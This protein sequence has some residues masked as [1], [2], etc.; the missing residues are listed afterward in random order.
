MT[1]F[2]EMLM[3]G[4]V[5]IFAGS[6]ILFALVALMFVAGLAYYFR[7]NSTL[8][9]GIAIVITWA[10]NGLYY[11]QNEQLMLLLTIMIVGFGIKLAF[12]F[13]NAFDR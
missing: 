8:S 11:Y 3:E 7:L 13:K 2:Y 5:Y 12:G 9:F 6:E 4:I 1:N 10:I